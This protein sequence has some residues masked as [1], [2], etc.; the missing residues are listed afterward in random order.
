[1]GSALVGATAG[2]GPPEC[3]PA[4]AGADLVAVAAGD[5]VGL[6]TGLPDG[7]L[8]GDGLRV[9]RPLECGPDG[10]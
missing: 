10:G 9:D 3:G 5:R 7:R 4:L 8:L 2:D 6:G 1:V